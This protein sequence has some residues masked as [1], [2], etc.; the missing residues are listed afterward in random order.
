[1]DTFITTIPVS[2]PPRPVVWPT[3]VGWERAGYGRRNLGTVA[4]P[5]LGYRPDEYIQTVGLTNSSSTTRP[6]LSSAFNVIAVGRTDGSHSRGCSAV[7]SLYTADRIRPDLVTPLGATSYATPVVGAAAALLIQTGHHNPALSTDSVQTSVT[8]RAGATIYNAERAEVIRAALTAGADRF[9][10]NTTSSDIVDY[11]LDEE[12]QGENGMDIRYGAGQ[13]NIFRSYSVIAAG[14]Q[15]S[16][17]D[18]GE[19]EVET[20]G[21]DYDPAFGV[22]NGCNDTATYTLTVDADHNL[23]TVAL[24]WHVKIDGGSENAF[25]GAATLYDLNLE[26]YDVAAGEVVAESAATEDNRENLWV[27][28]IPGRSYEIRVL[29]ASGQGVFYMGLCPCLD[30][31][32]R[33]RPGSRPG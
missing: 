31:R 18:G 13:L 15:N 8:T 33:C 23:L 6:L 25:D 14:E 16:L 17:E 7:D 22:E 9:T 19:S 10:A 5:G 24:V 29:V 26:L 1:M 32:G 21:F 11:R 4:P 12:N 28:L 3:T 20:C 30:H 27:A 2:R